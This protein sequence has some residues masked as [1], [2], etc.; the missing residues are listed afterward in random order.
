M[1]DKTLK[2]GLTCLNLNILQIFDL[3]MIDDVKASV[4]ESIREEHPIVS[5]AMKNVIAV[6]KT[7]I[8]R[9]RIEAVKLLEDI[10]RENPKHLNALAD[11]EKIYRESFRV[12]DADEAFQKIRLV[13]Q[14][15]STEDIQS[16]STCLLEQAFAI[17]LEKTLVNENAVCI[18]M[19]ELHKT[20]VSEFC[21]SEEEKRKSLFNALRHSRQVINHLNAAKMYKTSDGHHT[22]YSSSIDKFENADKICS[23]ISRHP[24][25]QFNYAKTL[26]QYYD[27]LEVI[28]NPKSQETDKTIKYRFRI[29]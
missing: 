1:E 29:Q 21:H 7:K 5:N 13:L 16:K 18:K 23:D 25:W 27:A 26:N 17:R 8:P 24:A 6:L 2:P 14:G 11:L 20:L 4:E 10:V 12:S 9:Q 19:S 28:C 3:A 15:T 22:R